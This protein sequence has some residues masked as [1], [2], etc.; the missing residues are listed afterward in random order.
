MSMNKASLQSPRQ[1]VGLR[2]RVQGESDERR[3][4]AWQGPQPGGPQPEA[5]AGVGMSPKGDGK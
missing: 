4:G 5:C 1:S 2:G 3:L